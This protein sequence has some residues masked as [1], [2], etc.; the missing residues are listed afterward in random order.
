MCTT[1]THQDGKERA[2]W[3]HQFC[4]TGAK[5]MDGVLGAWALADQETIPETDNLGEGAVLS[6]VRYH[7]VARAGPVHQ[8]Y[9]GHWNV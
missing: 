6:K 1:P 9:L 8:W 3:H 2:A 5:R 4:F 7:C